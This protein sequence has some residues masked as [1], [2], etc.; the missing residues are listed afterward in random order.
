MVTI[1]F[2][3]MYISLPNFGESSAIISLNKIS[4]SFL[5]SPPSGLYNVYISLLDGTS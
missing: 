3:W 2:V 4:I 1:S 5:L